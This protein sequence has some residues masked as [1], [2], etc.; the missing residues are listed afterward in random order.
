[1]RSTQARRGLGLPTTVIID[2]TTSDTSLCVLSGA[3]NECG[4]ERFSRRSGGGR[5][6]SGRLSPNRTGDSANGRLPVAGKLATL[7]EI[8]GY[9]ETNDKVRCGIYIEALL[10]A[11]VVSNNATS[12]PPPHLIWLLRYVAVS[13]GCFMMLIAPDGYNNEL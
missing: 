7:L 12:N 10:I 2:A 9:G 3:R 1:M 8:F 11:V 5:A 13:Y 4:T 6:V